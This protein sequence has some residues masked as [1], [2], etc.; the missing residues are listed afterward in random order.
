MY[1]PP[2]QEQT[3]APPPPAWKRRRRVSPSFVTVTAESS[4]AAAIT[5]RADN[6]SGGGAGGIPGC[7]ARVMNG[8]MGG[9]DSGTRRGRRARV[10]LAPAPWD[11]WRRVARR[12][13]V[14][15]ARGG[16]L[17]T[18]AVARGCH[19]VPRRPERRRREAEGE[20]KAGQVPAGGAEFRGEGKAGRCLWQGWLAGW[21]T[22]RVRA[23]RC[24]QPGRPPARSPSARRSTPG[25]YVSLLRLK[26][27]CR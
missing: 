19:A 2:P 22:A 9:A 17:A 10:G 7:C 20:G 6:D 1:M 13:G 12:A 15:T 18:L 24:P 23:C 4:A 5:Y 14:A 26:L 3:M 16:K 11:R 8:L 27:L 21:Q 25:I